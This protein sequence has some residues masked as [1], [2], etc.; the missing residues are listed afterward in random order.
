M[1]YS[2]YLYDTV[3]L[4][5]LAKPIEIWNF[6]I[7]NNYLSWSESETWWQRSVI[8]IIVILLQKEFF[9]SR[10]LWCSVHLHSVS[11]FW[12]NG[13]SQG[14]ISFCSCTCQWDFVESFNDFCKQ[15]VGKPCLHTPHA[16][17]FFLSTCSHAYG[18]ESDDENQPNVHVHLRKIV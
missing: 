17:V 1:V 13:S 3:L 18:R 16:R 12:V 4:A 11:N 15:K 9:E 14:P 8:S 2:L 7:I 5:S 6:G 10:D